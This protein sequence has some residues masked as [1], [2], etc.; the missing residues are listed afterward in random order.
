ML[1][2]RH[3]LEKPSGLGAGWTIGYRR[4][5]QALTESEQWRLR[6]FLLLARPPLLA[7]MQGG[8]FRSIP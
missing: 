2:K 6:D 8:E 4:W 1:I 7:V 3:G 5:L